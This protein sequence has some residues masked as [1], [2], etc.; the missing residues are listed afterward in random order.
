MD[1]YTEKRANSRMTIRDDV[2]LVVIG[3]ADKELCVLEDVSM[4]GARFFSTRKLTV[5]NHVE[6]RV[7]S[8][9][10]EPDVVIQAKILRVEPGDH[11]KEF[12]YG[13]KIESTE[14]A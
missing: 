4:G 14:N 13:C 12:G 8:T 6:L 7:P 9:E 2:T 1:D 10:D 3:V 5:G 11:S